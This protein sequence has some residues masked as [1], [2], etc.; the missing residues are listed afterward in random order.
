MNI[1]SIVGILN[2]TPDSFSDGGQYMSSEAAL[3]HARELVEQGAA[4]IDVGAEST[5]PGATPLSAEEE[6][7]RLSDILALLCDAYKIAIL[8]SVWIVVTP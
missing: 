3:A 4:V 2:V 5:R 6:W 7:A 8:L 1:P